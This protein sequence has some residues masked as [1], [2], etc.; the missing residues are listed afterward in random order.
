MT[1][2]GASAEHTAKRFGFAQCSTNLEN[3]WSDKNTDAIVALT[4]HQQHAEIVLQAITHQKSLFIEKPLCVSAEELEAIRNAMQQTTQ[5]PVIMVGH[6]RRFS[7][8]TQQ[9][10]QWLQYRADPLV[11]QLRV[12][13]GYVTADHWVH[14]ESQGRSR[15]VGEMSHYIDLLMAITGELPVRVFAERIGGDNVA[16]VNNDNVV[17]TLKFKQGSIANITYSAQG[18][19]SLSREHLQIF[20]AGQTIMS[21]DYKH[22]LLL[23]NGRKQKFNTRGQR[24]GYREELQ[25]FSHCVR[26]IE[27]PLVSNQQMLLTMQTIFAIEEAL[28]TGSSICISY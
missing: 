17:M 15:V 14:A 13:P 11:I 4:P 28:A 22:T 21:T 16:T 23:K 2:S 27:Q 7:P 18:N 20:V 10:Q 19:R 3:I 12:N 6:N 8:H 25:H 24:M 26:G 5:L 9:I 1:V